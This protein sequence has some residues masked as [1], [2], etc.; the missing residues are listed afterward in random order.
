MSDSTATVSRPTYRELKQLDREIAEA[1][2]KVMLLEAERY[3][4]ILAKRWVPLEMARPAKQDDMTGLL[5]GF[6]AW[7][8]KCPFARCEWEY[9][10]DE[11]TDDVETCIHFAH[12][13]TNAV[14]FVGP[15]E[16]LI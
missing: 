15:E 8:A 13:I 4:R 5:Y 10:R 6:V 11:I 7:L 16:D 14:L 3:G 2:H 12:E 1:K 9:T